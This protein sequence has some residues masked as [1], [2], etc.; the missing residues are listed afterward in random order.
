MEAEDVGKLWQ[1]ALKGFC[2]NK[3]ISTYKSEVNSM[4]KLNLIDMSVSI[5][6]PFREASRLY[7]S[8]KEETGLGVLGLISDVKGT[9]HC[10]PAISLR[11]LQTYLGILDCC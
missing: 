2:A 3:E 5:G 10:Q 11:N 6:V 1:T 9:C 8:V 4:L 7:Q